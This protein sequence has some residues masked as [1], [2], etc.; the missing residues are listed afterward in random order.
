MLTALE[1]GLSP[2]L[3]T[4]GPRGC[5]SMVNPGALEHGEGH[6]LSGDPISLKPV[7][8]LFSAPSLACLQGESKDS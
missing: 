6:Q 2:V 4:S 3:L 1:W 8:S 7:S 5:L